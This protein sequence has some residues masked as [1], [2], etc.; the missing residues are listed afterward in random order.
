[1]EKNRRRFIIRLP[2]RDG[3]KKN[4]T[5]TMAALET[6]LGIPTKPTLELSL[7]KVVIAFSNLLEGQGWPMFKLRSSQMGRPSVQ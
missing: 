6:W 3:L 2:P 7:K 5:Q 4:L 1:M